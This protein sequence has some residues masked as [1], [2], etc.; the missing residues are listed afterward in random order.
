MNV[1]NK[2]FAQTILIYEENDEILDF[3]SIEHFL[4]ICTNSNLWAKW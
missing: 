3:S 4:F 2:R 1:S